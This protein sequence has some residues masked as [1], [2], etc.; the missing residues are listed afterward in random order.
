VFGD[1]FSTAQ[2]TNIGNRFGTLQIKR[3]HF[4]SV[5]SCGSSNYKP[6]SKMVAWNV[7]IKGYNFWLEI[8]T[9]VFFSP[10][11]TR[12]L[13]DEMHQKKSQV[14]FGVVEE[15]EFPPTDSLNLLC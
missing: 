1:P 13:H 8:P 6:T 5:A 10:R 14:N 4:K 11:A 7:E 12:K 9:S 15:V 3:T 2:K